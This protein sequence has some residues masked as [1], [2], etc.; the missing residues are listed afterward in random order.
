MLE[1]VIEKISEQQAGKENTPVYAVG[2]QLKDI[3][4]AMPDVAEIVMQDLN[5][6]EMG[7]D[8]CEKKIKALADKRHKENKG[9]FAF[10]SP[11]EADG[12]IREFY[13]IPDVADKPT[14]E[15][16]IDPMDFL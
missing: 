13:G 5:I 10:V 9:N 8:E 7:I 15:K 6:P 4:R 1:R 14:E 11:A 2:E 12:I 3:L 16:I